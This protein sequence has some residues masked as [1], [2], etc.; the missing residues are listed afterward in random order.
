VNDTLSDGTEVEYRG[1]TPADAA[2]ATPLGL[3][4]RAVVDPEKAIKQIGTFADPLSETVLLGMEI[5]AASLET[6]LAEEV[7]Q[8][9][10]KNRKERGGL[11]LVK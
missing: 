8:T 5:M 7:D 4:R 6:A 1:V 11:R 2:T 9:E 3:I 10:A